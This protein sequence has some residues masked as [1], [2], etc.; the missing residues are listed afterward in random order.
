MLGIV[1]V[2]VLVKEDIIPVLQIQDL[3]IARRIGRELAE[4]EMGRECEGLYQ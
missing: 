4:N 2:S 3:T 1:G